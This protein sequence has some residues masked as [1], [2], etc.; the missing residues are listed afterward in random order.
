MDAIVLFSHGSLLCGSGE[1]LRRHA[2]RLKARGAAPVVEIGYLNYCEPLFAEAVAHCVEAGAARILVVPYFLV[3]GYFVKVDLPRVVSEVQASF[4]AL[5]FQIAEPIGFD[6]RLA[7][8]LI[9]SARSARTSETWR[10][11]LRNAPQ[12]C[13]NSPDCPLFS[14]KDCP[15]VLPDQETKSESQAKSPAAA[16]D[17]PDHDRYHNLD[18][19]KSALLIMVHGSPRP[20]ANA[21]MFW[22]VELVRQSNVFPVVEVGFMECNEPNIPCAIDACVAKGVERIL[23][24]P[25]FLHTGTHVADDL[26]TLL[27]QG[28]ERYPQIEFL[29]GD[30]LG[31]SEQLTDVLEQRIQ[32][33]NNQR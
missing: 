20:I 9:A 25:Y 12:H 7:D 8:A 24:V 15:H 33:A 5:E 17:K 23:A 19:A 3:P 18:P 6:A 16:S 14:T 30:Y 31:N 4:P 29:L 26:P 13:R 1:A 32:D 11:D 21:A 2:L 27:E 22:V 10:D 28:Q